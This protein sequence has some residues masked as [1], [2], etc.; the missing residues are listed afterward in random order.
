MSDTHTINA[1]DFELEIKLAT[2]SFESESSFEDDATDQLD[3]I[4]T[5]NSCFAKKLD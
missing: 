2:G 5:S 1:I 3:E 4:D